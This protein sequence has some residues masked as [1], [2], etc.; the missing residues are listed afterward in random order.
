MTFQSIFLNQ[1]RNK[2]YQLRQ[3][4]FISFIIYRI[5]VNISMT[6][7]LPFDKLFQTV[8]WI[9]EGLA[10]GAIIFSVTSIIL[11]QL[12]VAPLGNISSF[13]LLSL[14][15]IYLLS[16][17]SLIRAG[18]ELVEA[19]V[20][21]ILFAFTY[22]QSYEL[23]YHFSF[24]IYLNYFRLPILDGEGARYLIE[25][26]PAVLPIALMRKHM[27]FHRISAIFLLLFMTIWAI[28]LL[29]GFPQYFAQDTFYPTIL[30]TSDQYILSL[31]LNFGS[32][33]VLALFFISLL[34]L[35]LTQ[36]PVLTLL[37]FS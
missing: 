8:K 4:I 25:R 3:L 2:S 11:K 20:L 12:W 17:S 23:I 19:M 24:P 37:K 7:K 36:N 26:L 9:I 33:L 32:K 30:K 13:S 28:W 27:A 5:V 10:V 1:R 16:E 35:D 14:A 34:K 22:L 15:L 18:L 31:T 6:R 21:S 29:Y